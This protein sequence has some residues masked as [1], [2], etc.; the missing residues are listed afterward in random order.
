MERAKDIL[1]FV[2]LVQGRCFRSYDAGECVKDWIK[3]DS[4]SEEMNAFLTKKIL[5]KLVSTESEGEIVAL[6][7][8][9]MRTP[10]AEK[11][12]AIQTFMRAVMEIPRVLIEVPILKKL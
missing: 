5:S 10:A 12:A 2:S 8:A 3:L 9:F 4:T 6:S 11:E 1:N 7:E